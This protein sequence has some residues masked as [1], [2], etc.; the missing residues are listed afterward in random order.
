MWNYPDTGQWDSERNT[1]EFV[2]AMPTWRQH[3]MLSFTV[4][5]QG[6]N[7][8][9]YTHEQPWHNS[10]FYEDGTRRKEYFRRLQ[11]IL[12]RADSLG[13]APILGCF[14][15]GQDQSLRD[16]VARMKLIPIGE[17]IR[18]K[19]MLFCEDSIVRGTQL[20]GAIQRLYDCGAREVHMR[21]ACPPLAYSCKF[22]NFSRSRSELDLA[23]RK[24]MK[25]LAVGAEPDPRECT[26]CGSEKYRAVVERVRQMLRL[27]SLKYQ[28]LEDLVAAIGLPR[29]KLCTYCWD[30]TE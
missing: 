11:K 3:G 5:L 10:A 16:L 14:Y 24:A 9:G 8:Q 4:N 30:G 2:A 26:A 22:L 20:R 28:R 19:K 1:R 12:D 27:S 7:P 13:M 21:V 23:A 17:I 6:G 15:F 18:G 29:E 25:E